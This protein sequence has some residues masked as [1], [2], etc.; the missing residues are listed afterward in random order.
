[1]DLRTPSGLLFS[2][3]GLLLLI[4]GLFAPAYRAPLAQYN[5]NLF[6]GGLFLIVGV[7]MLW[8]AKRAS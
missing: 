7:A 3:Y 2:V 5:V 8:L 4:L 1:M 6:G